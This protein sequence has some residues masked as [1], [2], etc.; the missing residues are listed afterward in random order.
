MG[1]TKLVKYGILD[2]KSDIRLHVA[3]Q[4]RLV[5]FFH[6]KDGKEI[7]EKDNG[8]RRKKIRTGGIVTAVGLLV[9]PDDIPRCVFVGIPDDIFQRAAFPTNQYEGNTSDKG[10]RAVFVATKMLA[11]GLF[12]ITL[13]IDEIKDKAMQIEGFDITVK[14][15]IKIQVKCDWRAGH[16]EFGGT[17]NSFIRME[18]CN[19]DQMY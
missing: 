9:P 11:R 19:P 5:Y 15:K 4:A 17:G 7:V 3:V 14:T 18:E 6:T 13:R 8:Y 2:E 16:R 10:R 12:P 1:N